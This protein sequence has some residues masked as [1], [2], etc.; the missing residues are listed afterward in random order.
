M[1]IVALVSSDPQTAVITDTE[2]EKPKNDAVIVHM[3]GALCEIT[4]EEE[5]SEKRGA[6]VV[7]N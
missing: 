6:T 5:V 1:V 3:Q 2:S 7:M 4:Y